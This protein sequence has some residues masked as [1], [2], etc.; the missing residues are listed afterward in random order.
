MAAGEGE[1]AVEDGGEARRWLSGGE[2]KKGPIH[3][4]A[5]E[6]AFR[7]ASLFGKFTS[8][9]GAEHAERDHDV[10]RGVTRF[11]AAEM[12]KLVSIRFAPNEME[13]VATVGVRPE[14]GNHGS[15][16]LVDHLGLDGETLNGVS[17]GADEAGGGFGGLKAEGR[18]ELDGIVVG[19]APFAFEVVP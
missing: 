12:K 8:V 1:S 10:G 11:A 13:G 9:L 4:Y 3:D 6:H 2:R 14:G 17:A 7:F 16:A 15:G 5:L 18:C 19:G